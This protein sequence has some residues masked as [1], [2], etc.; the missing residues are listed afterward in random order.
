MKSPTLYAGVRLTCIS[1]GVQSFTEIVTILMTGYEYV[2]K[3]IAIIG[4][5]ARADR[6]E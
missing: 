2:A 4:M 5:F 6:R 3:Q 1:V